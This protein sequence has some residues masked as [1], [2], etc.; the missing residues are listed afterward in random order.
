MEMLGFVATWTPHDVTWNLMMVFTLLAL[1]DDDT[2]PLEAKRGA[3]PH[4]LILNKKGGFPRNQR[5]GRPR[6]EQQAS[7]GREP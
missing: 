3:M 5:G 2:W 1:L 4:H 7:W 6:P